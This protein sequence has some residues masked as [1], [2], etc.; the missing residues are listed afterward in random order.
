R[1]RMGPLW[2]PGGQIDHRRFDIR[3]GPV[4]V[5]GRS[6]M[7]Q[8]HVDDND[9]LRVLAGSHNENLKLI[10]RRLGVQVGQR[11]T[12]L[13]VSGPDDA[14]EFAQR[15]L[16][17]LT[18]LVKAGR[19]L[20]KEDAEQAIKVL[21]HQSADETVSVVMAPVLTRAGGRAI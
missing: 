4:L 17:Q 13:N 7:K 9:L 11:G 21:G 16:T 5:N 2:A 19:P 15:L 6:L 1:A 12:E 8:I 3:A 14:A 20:F 18:E 10:E